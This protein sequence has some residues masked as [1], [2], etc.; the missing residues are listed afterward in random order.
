MHIGFF[1]DQHPATL[2]G[3][4]VSL[5]LQRKYLQR[6]GHSVTV[7]APNSKHTTPPFPAETNDV[8]L[9]AV[10]VGEHSFTLAGTR[11]DDTIDLAFASK[12]PV[13]C[14]HVQGDLWGAWNGYRFAA[15][16]DLPL[17][18]TMHTNIE[19]GLPAILPFPRAVFRLLFYA[20]Q[21]FLNAS[22][23]R[24]IA[25]YT[26]A[27]AERAD[28]VIAPSTHFAQRLRGYGIDKEIWVVPTG[29]DDEL[30][31]ALVS[32]PRAP[33]KRPIL[34]WPGRISQEKRIS[35]FFE[36][37]HQASVDADIHVYGSGVDLINAQ[38]RAADLGIANRVYFFGAVS[39]QRVLTAMRNADAVV[40]SSL[41]YETQGLTVYEA[42][43]VGTPVILRDR[44]IAADLPAEFSRVAAN[45]SIDAFAS[46]IREF[47]QFEHEAGVRPKPSNQFA[48]S[49]QTRRLET[50][51][52]EAWSIHEKSAFPEQSGG[53]QRAA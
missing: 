11:F 3:L 15:R 34:L 28:I 4:Q 25:D 41:G 14:V 8:P 35:D 49:H 23:V 51:Y 48:Q 10:R 7:C 19:V 31:Q 21:R 2:G 39:H 18:H 36:A 53:N 22:K 13:D 27:F 20:Q 45:E 50:L 46:A 52:R 40:Q 9:G 6:R 26:R 16:H 43:S 38:K 17:V 33:R 30:I 12:P 1:S 37:F 5:E 24:S 32:E 44:N 47:V 42:V 29:V